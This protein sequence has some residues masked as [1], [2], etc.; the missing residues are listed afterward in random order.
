MNKYSVWAAVGY[1]TY[2]DHKLNPNTV[3]LHVQ[4]IINDVHM[5]G[6]V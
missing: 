3:L 2:Q 4:H 6:S 1:V 5:I